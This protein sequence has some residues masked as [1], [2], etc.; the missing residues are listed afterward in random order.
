[1]ISIFYFH[2]FY[3]F[4][5]RSLILKVAGRVFDIPAL[6]YAALIAYDAL[7]IPLLKTVT[8]FLCSYSIRRTTLGIT[9]IYTSWRKFDLFIEIILKI[10]A[11]YNIAGELR[12]LDL[13]FI[14]LL[15]IINNLILL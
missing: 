4:L 3:S 9:H 15:L 11:N 7:Y 14:L 12:I 2:F 1:M 5:F 8:F 6:G 13:L 10:I